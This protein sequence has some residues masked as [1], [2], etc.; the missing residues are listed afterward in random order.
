MDRCYFEFIKLLC[1]IISAYF[2]SLTSLIRL[3]RPIDD[4]LLKKWIHI[5]S[6]YKPNKALIPTNNTMVTTIIRRINPPPC[7]NRD[8]PLDSFS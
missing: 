8:F 3:F 4:D 7:M 2:L 6:F 5:F 1:D